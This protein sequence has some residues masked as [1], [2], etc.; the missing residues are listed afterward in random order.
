MMKIYIDSEYRC[1]VTNQDG[2]YRELILSES[3]KAFFDN[4]CITFI[5]GYRFIPSDETWTREDGIAFTG[6]MFFPWKNY[7]ELDVAQREYEKELLE[8]VQKELAE[9]D[10]ALLE[11]QYN[12]LMEDL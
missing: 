6:E 7:S 3:A 2:F 12:N 9:L 8:E 5:E 4:K 1:H 10:A 11:I